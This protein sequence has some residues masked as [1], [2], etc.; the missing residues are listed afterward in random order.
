MFNLD[1]KIKGIMAKMKT[2]RNAVAIA[3]SSKDKKPSPAHNPA[4]RKMQK[5]FIT[6]N[7]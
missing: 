7:K 2:K 4:P 6:K 5:V 3:A 1:V